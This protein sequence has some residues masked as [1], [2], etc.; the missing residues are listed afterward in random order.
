MPLFVGLMCCLGATNHQIT[1]LKTR[2]GLFVLVRLLILGLAAFKIKAK[3]KLSK[4]VV[5]V[6]VVNLR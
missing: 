4:E 2:F 5:R 1:L 6:A 3:N